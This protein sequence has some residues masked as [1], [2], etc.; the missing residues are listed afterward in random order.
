[1]AILVVGFGGG[2]AVW[3]GGFRGPEP[4]RACVPL[5]TEG[6]APGTFGFLPLH[7]GRVRLTAQTAEPL[8]LITFRM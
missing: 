8:S 2:V 4:Q 1:M 6:T 3:T 5:L 7:S